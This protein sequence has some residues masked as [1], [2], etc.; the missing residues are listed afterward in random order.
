MGFGGVWL[1]SYNG[2]P[3]AAGS[4]WRLSGSAD[5]KNSSGAERRPWM[6]P[7]RQHR[8]PPRRQPVMART[9]SRT[10][11]RNNAR[12]VL[13]STGGALG[14]LVVVQV[15]LRKSRDF[16]PD[17]LASVLLYGLTV[18]NI[19]LL[20]VLVLVLGGVE[21]RRGGG[22]GGFRM[23]LVIV[24]VLMAAAPALLLMVV[25]SDLIQQTVDR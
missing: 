11:F 13:L 18:L 24:F 5:A 10:P 3:A 15:L 19:T 16:S 22:G 17:F 6:G 9:G 20:L 21:R 2:S 8:T 4:A 14:L 23:R 1:A 25:G 12:L 7:R